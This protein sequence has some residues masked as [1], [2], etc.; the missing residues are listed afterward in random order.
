[1]TKNIWVVSDTHFNHTNIIRYCNRPFS[2]IEEMNEKI[3][4]N[5]NKT[6]QPGDIVYHLG[7]FGYDYKIANRL[8]GRKRL[9]LGNHD[10]AKNKD[11]L[12]A[13]QKVLMW[14]MFP[15]FKLLLTHV[16]VHESS[17]GFKTEKNVHGHVHLNSVKDDRY[18]NVCVEMID[19]TPVNIETLRL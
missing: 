16:P 4:E 15:E 17:L 10:D 14:R 9:I 3:I 11:L 6:V 12:S 5:W 7:D 2:S 1:M 8:I 19:Y 18:I 13:F